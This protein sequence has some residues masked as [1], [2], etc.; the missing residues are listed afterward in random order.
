MVM[1]AYLSE[2]TN[3]RRAPVVR[4]IALLL[5]RGLVVGGL[6]AGAASGTAGS[7]AARPNVDP[8]PCA[9][10]GLFPIP[11][12]TSHPPECNAATMDPVLSLRV[13]LPDEGNCLSVGDEPPPV[14]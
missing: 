13:D 11:S 8:P 7:V 9:S 6:V 3:V 2:S 5:A 14:A 1:E 12:P 4:R 10:A